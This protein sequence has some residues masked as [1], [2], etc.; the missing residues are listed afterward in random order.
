[1]CVKLAGLSL[2]AVIYGLAGP[3]I[4]SSSR[5]RQSGGNDFETGGREARLIGRGRSSGVLFLRVA[6]CERT[7]VLGKRGRVIT[8]T[9][10]HV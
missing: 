4:H 2:P 1:M 10:D 5:S 9:V 6:N 7:D 8:H 3:L